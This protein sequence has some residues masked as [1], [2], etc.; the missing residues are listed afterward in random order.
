M[1]NGFAAV[2][3]PLTAP[4][5]GISA[6][7]GPQPAAQTA[8]AN[9]TAG[10]FNRA[11]MTFPPG[12]NLFSRP[13]CAAPGCS[14]SISNHHQPAGAGFGAPRLARTAEHLAHIGAALVALK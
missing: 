9:V 12:S 14:R 3:V 13:A 1:V 2:T 6:K 8:R 5:P 10:K 4:V 11:I 7:A